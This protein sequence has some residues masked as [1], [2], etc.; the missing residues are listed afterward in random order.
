MYEILWFIL[1]ATLV[2]CVD[3]QNGLG[4]KSE[5]HLCMV[6]QGDGGDGDKNYRIS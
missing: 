3:T 1:L 5:K 4:K 2:S 6:G